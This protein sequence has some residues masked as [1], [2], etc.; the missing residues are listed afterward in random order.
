VGEGKMT[1]TELHPNER[2]Q[3]QL[4]F[5]K[6]FKGT[7]TAEFTFKPQGTETVVIWTMSGKN[8]IITKTVGLFMNCDKMVGGQFDQGLAQIKSIA[9]SEAKTARTN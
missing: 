9:E 7:N 4:D 1:L 3:L 5:E 2:L 6:P 8:N